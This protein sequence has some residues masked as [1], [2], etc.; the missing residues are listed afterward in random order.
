M[1]KAII[2]D[3]FEKLRILELYKINGST[4]LLQEQKSS[5]IYASTTNER[6]SNFGPKGNDKHGLKGNSSQENFYFKTNLLKLYHLSTGD[7]ANFLSS[8]EPYTD[9]GQYID[10]VRIGQNEITNSGKT[11]IDLSNVKYSEIEV[12]ATHNGLLVIKRLMDQWKGTKLGFVTLEMSATYRE[13][14][15]S[16]YDL[17]NLKKNFLSLM[18]G[19][20]SAISVLILNNRKS[21]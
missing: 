2:I 18:N 10:Y 3:E 8:F 1:G 6:M 5:I 16:D 21:I 9:A 11:T 7:S 13:S 14:K 19:I 4:N 12:I 17:V 20:E 15:R